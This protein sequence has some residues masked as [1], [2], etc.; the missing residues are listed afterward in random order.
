LGHC[1]QE[2]GKPHHA[3]TWLERALEVP[4]LA[5][6]EQHGIW[7]ELALAHEAEG[8]E[9]RS[10]EFFERIYAENVDFRDVATRVREHLISH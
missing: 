3:V 7:Y 10:A 5:D 1:F 2:S 8:D 9:D 4:Q 6:D